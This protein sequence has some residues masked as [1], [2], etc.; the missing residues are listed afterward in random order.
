MGGREV[1]DVFFLV[2][3]V[4]AL[5]TNLSTSCAH[6]GDKLPHAGF[7]ESVEAGAFGASAND[8]NTCAHTV[9]DW[10]LFDQGP[11]AA[12]SGVRF[13]QLVRQRREHHLFVFSLCSGPWYI[14]GVVWKPVIGANLCIA[15]PNINIFLWQKT[16]RREV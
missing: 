7:G 1:S 5:E 8:D 13:I 3:L 11:C 12:V 14:D 6:K 16:E 2:H 15:V 4:C 10:G 9:F